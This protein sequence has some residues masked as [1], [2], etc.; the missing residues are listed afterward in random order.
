MGISI[1][2]IQNFAIGGVDRMGL[3]R[4]GGATTGGARKQR[5]RLEGARRREQLLSDVCDRRAGSAEQQACQRATAMPLSRALLAIARPACILLLLGASC[6][7]AAPERRPRGGLLSARSTVGTSVANLG[8][9]H[10][11]TAIGDAYTVYR[12]S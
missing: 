5:R 7:W 11:G 8:W 2:R 10:Q 1:H 4:A 12:S 6:L 9:R 3:A